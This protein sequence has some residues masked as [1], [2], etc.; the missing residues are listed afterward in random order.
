MAWGVQND[1][2]DGIILLDFYLFCLFVFPL[3][4]AKSA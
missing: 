3:L 2:K 4:D 1:V